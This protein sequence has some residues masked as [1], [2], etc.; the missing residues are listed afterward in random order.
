MTDKCIDNTRRQVHM[1]AGPALTAPLTDEEKA[2]LKM[3]IMI[4]ISARMA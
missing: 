3:R 4:A 2:D 1:T